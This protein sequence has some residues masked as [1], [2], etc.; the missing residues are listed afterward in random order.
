M[1]GIFQAITEC[2][3]LYPDTEQLSSGEEGEEGE[4]WEE[5]GEEVTEL[6]GGEFFTSLEGVEHLTPE[7]QAVL[8]HL[9]RVF[10]MPSPEEFQHMVANG[11][12]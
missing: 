2:Q 9:E 10:Q 4:E 1:D 5:E 6:S 11:E 7:G 12:C 3:A 8:E